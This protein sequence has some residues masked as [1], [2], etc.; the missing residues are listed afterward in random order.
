VNRNQIDKIESHQ[1]VALQLFKI[2][3]HGTFAEHGCGFCSKMMRFCRKVR[4]QF[5]NYQRDYSRL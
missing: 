5:C 4:W 2:Q 1:L 3:F